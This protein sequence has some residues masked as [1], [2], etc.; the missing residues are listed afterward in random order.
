MI[1]LQQKSVL[2][3]SSVKRYRYFAGLMLNYRFYDNETMRKLL[4]APL[5]ICV[6]IMPLQ[7]RLTDRTKRF[8]KDIVGLQ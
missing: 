3:R 6:V 4:V 2:S 7:P 1:A 5:P 8:F